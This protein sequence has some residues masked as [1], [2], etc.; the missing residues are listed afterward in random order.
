MN[1]TVGPSLSTG[2]PPSWTFFLG[3]N[4]THTDVYDQPIEHRR[5]VSVQSSSEGAATDPLLGTAVN[6]DDRNMY[7]A[8][9]VE[10]HDSNAV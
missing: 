5:T 6:E 10:G 4:H 9:H 2:I 7:T 3:L 8:I 1:A